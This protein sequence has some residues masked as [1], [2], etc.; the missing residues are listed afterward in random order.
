MG[1][2]KKQGNREGCAALIFERTLARKRPEHLQRAPDATAVRAFQS[3][4]RTANA[5]SGLGDT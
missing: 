4:R 2:E 5:S 3:R 1:E